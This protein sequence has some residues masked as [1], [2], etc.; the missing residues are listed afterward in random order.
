MEARP[1][2]QSVHGSQCI[3]RPLDKMWDNCHKKNFSPAM[4]DVV[5]DFHSHLC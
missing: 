5:I 1:L 4:S 3:W 2:A